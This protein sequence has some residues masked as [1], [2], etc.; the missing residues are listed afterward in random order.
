MRYLRV[1]WIHSH[2]DDPV[3]LYSELDDTGWE[4]RKVEMFQDGR[5]GF[6][7]LSEATPGTELGEKPVPALEAIAADPQFKP[8]WIS[9]DEFEK[10]WAK[11]FCP[12][13]ES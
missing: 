6:A 3:M 12:V 5:I 4:M 11:R 10:V 8:A 2:P 7:S 1:Q 9:H 13:P